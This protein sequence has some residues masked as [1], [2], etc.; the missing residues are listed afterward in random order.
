[1]ADNIYASDNGDD[2]MPELMDRPTTGYESDSSTGSSDEGGIPGR[3]RAGSVTSM[4][5]KQMESVGNYWD[6]LS[7]DEQFFG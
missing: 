3:R 2:D 1:M 4:L 6:D 5:R 7:D